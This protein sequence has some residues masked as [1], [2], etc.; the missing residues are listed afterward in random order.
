MKE[1]LYQE[2]LMLCKVVD[3]Y[4]KT[5]LKKYTCADFEIHLHCLVMRFFN[6]LPLFFSL[7]NWTD[8]GANQPSACHQFIERDKLKETDQLF[9]KQ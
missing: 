5:I 7:S 9:L 4:L 6:C 2:S 3:L 1:Y 8:N